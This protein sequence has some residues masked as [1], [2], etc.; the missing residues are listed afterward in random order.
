LK[1]ARRVLKA[2]GLLVLTVWKF[3]QLKECCLRFK[4][5]ILKLIGKS[6][7]DWGDILEPWGKKIKRYYHC[8]SKKRIGKLS[9][10]IRIQN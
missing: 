2:E 9:D 3:P 4:Y 10:K 5:T 6:K 7:L 8:F 1:E